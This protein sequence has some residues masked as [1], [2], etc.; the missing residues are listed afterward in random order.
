MDLIL[1]PALIWLALISWFDIR[2]RQIPHSA[3]VGIPF[4]LGL[5]YRAMNGGW[6]LSLL[7]LVVV[8]ASERKFGSSYRYLRNLR[9]IYSWIPFIGILV[10][11]AG[12]GNLPAA[13]AILGFWA[14]WEMRFWGGADALVSITLLL[15]WPDAPLLISFILVNLILALVATLISLIQERKLRTHHLPGL[16]I[17]LISVIGRTILTA[18]IR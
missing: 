17:L 12:Q 4:L 10:Y 16:P 2:T 1:F 3:W 11:L 7:A 9:S 13:L 5:I 14:A 8:L 18:F 15:C 6:D